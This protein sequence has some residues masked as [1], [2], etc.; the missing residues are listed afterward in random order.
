MHEIYV[1]EIRTSKIKKQ[2]VIIEVEA[3][4]PIHDIKE[5][6]PIQKVATYK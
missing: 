6:D 5:T 3:A 2:N 4:L 1:T